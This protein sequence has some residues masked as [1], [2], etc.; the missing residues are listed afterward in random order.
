MSGLSKNL[1]LALTLICV[2]VLIVF[3]IQLIVINRGLDP[4]NPGSSVSGGP[5]QGS[6]S[7][8]GSGDGPGDGPGDGTGDGSGDSPGDGSGDGSGTAQATPRPPPQGARHELLVTLNSS[9]VIY[10]RENLFDFEDSGMDWQ[11]IY[12]GG[13]TASL[14]ILD[15][16]PSAQGLAATA[17]NFLNTYTSSTGTTVHGDEF[18]HGSP[19]RGYHATL[20]QNE[21]TYEAWVHKLAGSDLAVV[22]II[23]YQNDQQRDALYEVLSTLD[24]T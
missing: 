13:G 20:Q 3:C 23:N 17:E 2:I 22:L 4:Q 6:G 12:T 10:A 14:K 24:I 9:L 1:L 8:Q 7:G 15:I 18:I 21:T 11:F 5:G 16:M 19:L